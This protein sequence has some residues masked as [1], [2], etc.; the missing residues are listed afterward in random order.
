MYVSGLGGGRNFI[1]RYRRDV[2]VCCGGGLCFCLVYL[3]L[4]YFSQSDLAKSLKCCRI[5]RCSSLVRVLEVGEN[6][7]PLSRSCK[8]SWVSS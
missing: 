5:C 4:A 6:V 3:A 2:V 8:S 1:C 7:R